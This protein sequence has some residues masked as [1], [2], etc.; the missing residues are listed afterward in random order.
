MALTDT[1]AVLIV[2]TA[3]VAG[4]GMAAFTITAAF[5]AAYMAR[6]LVLA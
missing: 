4:L 1:E 3:M 2:V 5:M 6:A